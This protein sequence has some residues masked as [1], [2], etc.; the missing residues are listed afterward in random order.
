MRG[1]FDVLVLNEVKRTAYENLRNETSSFYAVY[2][3]QVYT[4]KNHFFGTIIMI[5]KEID[6]EVHRIPLADGKGKN[7]LVAIIGDLHLV[8]LHLDSRATKAQKLKW[9][10][11]CILEHSGKMTAI[12]GDANCPRHPTCL[13]KQLFDYSEK[14]L[15]DRKHPDRVWLKGLMMQTLQTLDTDSS[16]HD[17]YMFKLIPYRG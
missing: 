8:A 16:D 5:R 2:C 12:I 10:Q 3:S 11:D 4:E 7:V 9:V 14:R 15:S 1:Y 6:A 13:G 17:A